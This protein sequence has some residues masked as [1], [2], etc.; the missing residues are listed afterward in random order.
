MEI[1][2]IL[3]DISDHFPMFLKSKALEEC[4]QRK[5][6]VNILLPFFHENKIEKFRNSH[7]EIN[8]ILIVPSDE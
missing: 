5:R 8:W 2:K 1:G 4:L 7:S 6:K 3:T